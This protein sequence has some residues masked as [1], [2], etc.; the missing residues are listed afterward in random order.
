MNAKDL[1]NMDMEMATQWLLHFW[2]WWSNELLAMLPERWRGQ[3]SR[4]VRATAELKGDAL[5]YRDAESGQPMAAKPRGRVAFLMA[6]NQVLVRELELPLLPLGDVKRMLALEIDRLTPFQP[7]QVYFDA[8]IL[9]RDPDSGRQQVAMGVVRRETAA[10]AL[11]DVRGRDLTPL[12]LGVKPRDGGSVPPFDFLAAMREAEGGGASHRRAVY[13]WAAAAAL[14]I[15]NLVVFS[16]RDAAGLEQLRQAVE[17]QQAPV[18][19]AMRTRERVGKEQARRQ[20]LLDIK[21]KTSPLPVLDAVTAAMPMDAWVRRFEWNGR[22]VRLIGA[23]KTSQD[24]LARL[25]A[26]PYLRNARSL[27]SGEHPDASGYQPFEMTAEREFPKL[28]IAAAEP[29]R[30]VPA[31]MRPVPGR[32]GQTM[33]GAAGRQPMP[34]PPGAAGQ[35]PP[36][37]IFTPLI[38]R[39]GFMPP[40]AMRV[41]PP[42]KA[43]MQQQQQQ[44][45]QQQQQ[46][47]KQLQQQQPPQQPP[48]NNTASDNDGDDGGE[49]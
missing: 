13:W 19:V 12:A 14:L 41:A 46:Q 17:S 32:P 24:I 31:S 3:L 35:L 38:R 26:S 15:L 28:R 2:R 44:L 34:L 22:S 5:V 40:G 37:A 8:A 20:A 47:P 23:R 33:P 36:N 49:P 11:E 10:Q 45:Q 25:E 30:P 1:L 29:A 6:P 43:L 27:S 21:M 18:S 9:S 7:E 4:K 39:P 42:P 16:W 48:A